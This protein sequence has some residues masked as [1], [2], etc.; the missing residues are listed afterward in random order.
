[1]HAIFEG[2]Y[3]V[4]TCRLSGPLSIPRLQ[5]TAALQGQGRFSGRDGLRAVPFFSLLLGQ[6]NL[7]DGTE[8]VPPAVSREDHWSFDQD[9]EGV[10]SLGAVLI[11]ASFVLVATRACAQWWAFIGSAAARDPGPPDRSQSVVGSDPF[12]GGMPS[13]PSHFSPC[14]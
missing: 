8:P 4:A 7:W 5:G 13:V 14:Y 9:L 11:D 3:K 12:Q 10:R 1:M 6:L 2:L